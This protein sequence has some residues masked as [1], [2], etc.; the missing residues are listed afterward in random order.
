LRALLSGFYFVASQ[1]VIRQPA[2][3]CIERESKKSFGI[4]AA[5]EALVPFWESAFLM[6][7]N[8]TENEGRLMFV[9]ELPPPSR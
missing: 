2:R 8:D 1:I 4:I 6:I 7:Q 3:S 5:S 9:A